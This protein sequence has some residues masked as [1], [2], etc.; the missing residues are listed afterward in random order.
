MT[1]KIIA[2]E[3][4]KDELLAITPTQD[5]HFDFLPM[6]LHSKPENLNL[7]L[8]KRL[9]ESKGYVRVVL[10]FGLCG[11]GAK[12]LKASH[13]I[14]TI[15]RVHD[16]IPL[17]LGTRHQFDELRKEEAGTLYHTRGWLEGYNGDRTILPDFQKTCEKYGE[18]KAAYLFK[19]IYEGY[20]RVLF[21][22]IG[23]PR[24]SSLRLQSME[25][26]KKLDLKYQEVSG[27]MAYFEKIINGPYD[28][29]NF[30]N[31]PVNERVDELSF[32]FPN[33]PVKMEYK[34]W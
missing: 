8:Q 32:V 18:K 3:V 23:H 7:E 22:Q 6:A 27:S 24:E 25:T 5:V 31:I 21:I 19:R 13:C 15:P 16:C 1:V 9:N 30:V 29:N 14:L 12:N 2:C 17:I 20:T 34:R 10:G 28:D 4:M 11:G 26:A 33:E